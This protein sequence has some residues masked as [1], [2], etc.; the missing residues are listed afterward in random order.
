[1]PA[2]SPFRR[3]LEA[4]GISQDEIADRTGISA[5]QISRWASGAHDPRPAALQ[6]IATAFSATPDE[7]M[8]RA[9]VPASPLR[10]VPGLTSSE[11][12][13]LRQLA[14]ARETFARLTPTRSP[15]QV[16]DFNAAIE[17]AHAAVTVHKAARAHPEAWAGFV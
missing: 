11:N 14:L 12:E 6:A 2:A 4:R 16:A 5:S 13:I 15:E 10:S 9:A 17:A 1:M 8:G 3:W 7:I